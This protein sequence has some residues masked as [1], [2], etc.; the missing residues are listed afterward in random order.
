MSFLNSN[1]SST[2]SSQSTANTSSNANLQD[3]GGAAVGQAGGDVT[4][5]STDH[6][7]IGNATDL[8]MRS[9]SVAE[10]VASDA[11][12]FSL[13]TLESGFNFGESAF[14]SVDQALARAAGSFRDA[15]SVQQDALDTVASAS[16]GFLQSALSFVK[17]IQS[18]TSTIIGNQSKG[19]DQRIA[20]ISDNASKYMLYAV[21]AIAASV[22]LYSIFKKG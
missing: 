10:N 6:N 4:I 7:A 14:S 16:T 20:E 12:S 11:Q 2:S 13:R 17:D 5:V 21:G 19:A 1:R 18:Q 9:L 15:A 3:I 8:A 22:V